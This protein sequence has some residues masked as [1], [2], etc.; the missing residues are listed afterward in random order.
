MTALINEDTGEQERDQIAGLPMWLIVGDDSGTVVLG[1]ACEAPA[2][3]VPL[4]LPATGDGTTDPGQR[5]R[6]ARALTG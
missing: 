1:S 5:L 3:E 6:G 2:P 4:G